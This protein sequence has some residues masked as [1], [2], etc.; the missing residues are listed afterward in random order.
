[1]VLSKI[2]SEVSYP[3]LKSV[4]YGDLK[5]EAELY[6][7]EINEI[8]VVIALGN[9]KNTFEDKNVLYFPIYL[10]KHNNKVIQ[11][12]LYEIKATDYLSYLDEYNDLNVDKMPMPLIYSFA[13]KEFLNKL[14]LKPEPSLE[15][16]DKEEGEDYRN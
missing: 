5:K 8:D 2:N 12:G 10:V 15:D 3:E 14:R 11:I 16:K 7:V 1:M 4:D 13:N 9:S 6:Q